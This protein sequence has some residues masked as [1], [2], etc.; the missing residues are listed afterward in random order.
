MKKE[1][2]T[3]T[4][5][6]K[7]IEANVDH[8]SWQRTIYP[9]RVNYFINALKSNR[10]INSI[11]T[12][13]KNNTGKFL[14]LDGQHRIKAILDGDFEVEMDV[15]ILSEIDNDV[16]R[17]EYFIKNNVKQ[18]RL[19][20]DINFYQDEF[21]IIKSFMDEKTFPINVTMGGG[22]NSM[23]IDSLLNV[24]RN[25]YMKAATRSNMTRAK[26]VCFLGGID[27]KKYE[28]V[29]QFCSMYGK[30]F[31]DPSK[32]NWVYRNIVM[33]TIMR[34]WLANKDFFDEEDFIVT[35]RKIEGNAPIRQNSNVT[36]IDFLEKMTMQIYKVI[37]YKRSQNK[38]VLFWE[39]FGNLGKKN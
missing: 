5:N 31:G 15:L 16:A 12:L 25:G 20:D 32:D 37:N 3:M 2:K 18:H 6:K 17:E 14:L 7:W 10:F 29:K 27:Q 36:S 35:F 26:L 33:F 34:I 1:F 23:R 38:F 19:I 39:D 11:L 9:A 22:V 13:E 4:I 21:P 24:I 28:E 30:C 8:Y